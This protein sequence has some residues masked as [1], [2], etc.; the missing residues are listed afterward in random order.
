MRWEDA[1]YELSEKSK[2]LLSGECG[3]NDVCRF[4]V[5][6][7]RRVRVVFAKGNTFLIQQEGTREAKPHDNSPRRTGLTRDRCM[8][9]ISWLDSPFLDSASPKF[10]VLQRRS[11]SFQKNPVSK[12]D[13]CSLEYCI[14]HC[15]L[16]AIVTWDGLWE[17]RTGRRG[18]REKGR[19]LQ[20]EKEKAATEKR[21]PRKIVNFFFACGHAKGYSVARHPCVIG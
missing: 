15:I 5:S 16:Q 2:P 18:R 10:H 17:G 3:E 1:G 11:L 19:K 21:T 4:R 14:T 7:G 8:F 20:R 12:Y 6:D 9:C 13:C